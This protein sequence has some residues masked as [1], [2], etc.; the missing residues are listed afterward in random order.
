FLYDENMKLLACAVMR[1]MFLFGKTFVV[2]D[3]QARQ[4]ALIIRSM[5]RLTRH[6]YIADLNCEGRYEMSE[7]SALKAVF[8]KMFGHLWGMLRCAYVFREN[9]EESGIFRKDW[10]LLN[11]YTLFI[12]NPP[13]VDYRVVLL[14]GLLADRIDPDRWY[15]WL[16]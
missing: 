8:R 5:F 14:M 1:P 4:V 12:Q 13:D 2:Y 6:W 16:N 10:S 7:T 15:P 9:G 11:R 3:P